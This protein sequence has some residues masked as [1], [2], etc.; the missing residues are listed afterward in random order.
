MNRHARFLLLGLPL[1][2]AA[3]GGNMGL[4][5]SQV[6][7]FATTA[8]AISTSA[9]GYAAQATTMTSASTCASL[10]DAYDS[11]VRPM[12]GSMQGMAGEMDEMMGS[13]N[14]MADG[15]MQCGAGA[16]MAEL[17]RH[18]AAACAS[19]TDMSPNVAEARQHAT[20]MVQ[21]ADHQAARA[22]EMGSMM[23]MSGMMGG[24]GTGASSWTGHCVHGADG[25]YTIQ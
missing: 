22:H 7:A 6:Q 12:V 1:G 20:V 24:S 16:M 10:Q 3:C 23:G 11:Q 17:D 2:L 14:H 19:P 25:S 9:S 21:W 18:M 13:M 15:D 4:D 8:Q 5:S